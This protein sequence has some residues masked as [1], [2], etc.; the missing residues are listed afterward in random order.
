MA[1]IGTG[2]ALLIIVIGA[3]WHHQWR[4]VLGSLA[5]TLVAAIAF[6]ALRGADPNCSDPRGH[7]RSSLLLAGCWLGGLGLG[8]TATGAGFWIL[9]Y[10]VCMVGA[11]AVAKR[12]PEFASDTHIPAVFR[13]PLVSAVVVALVASLIAGT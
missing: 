8:P 5:G 13:A 3:G 1:A 4:I 12:A 9:T 7:G 11:W 10:F 2:A 6:A